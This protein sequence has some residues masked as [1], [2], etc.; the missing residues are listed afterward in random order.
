MTKQK[1]KERL[2]KV[3]DFYSD[4]VIGMLAAFEQDDAEITKKM[5]EFMENNPDAHTDD[6][7]GYHIDILGLT[8]TEME[9]VD[10]DELDEEE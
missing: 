7:I 10:D 2:R 5:I 6:I 3:P 8:G 1:Y 4:F 9:I